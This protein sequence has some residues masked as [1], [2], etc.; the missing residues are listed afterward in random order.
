MDKREN[1]IKIHMNTSENEKTYSQMGHPN[2]MKKLIS[3]HITNLN[4]VLTKS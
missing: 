2:L 1:F 3:P 4:A